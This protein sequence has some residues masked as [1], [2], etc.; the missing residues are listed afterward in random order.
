M[1]D[2]IVK[3]HDLD[4]GVIEY[5]EFKIFGNVY[6]FRHMNTEEIKVMS[7][8]GSDGMKAQEYLNTFI[9]PVDPKDPKFEEVQKKMTVPHL[10]KFQNMVKEEF[11]INGN[12][13]G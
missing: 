7:G 11:G 4:E 9:T 5:F 1:S 2:I 10:L 6:K 12:N 13:Q 8:F 3:P